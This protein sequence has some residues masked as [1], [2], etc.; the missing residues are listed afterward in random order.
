[1]TNAKNEA[2]AAQSGGR[3]QE[4]GVPYC[5]AIHATMSRSGTR[6]TGFDPKATR[7]TSNSSQQPPT[8][9]PSRFLGVRHAARPSRRVL[10]VGRSS[11]RAYRSFLP[12][13]SAS[14]PRR[15][16]KKGKDGRG[17]NGDGKHLCVQPS[18]GLLSFSSSLTIDIEL[19]LPIDIHL[20][21][22]AVII[23]A[24]L[25]SH[26]IRPIT[27]IP[28]PPLNLSGSLPPQS[29]VPDN[30][31]I[32]NFPFFF[33]GMQHISRAAH[34][35]NNHVHQVQISARQRGHDVEHHITRACLWYCQR[36]DAVADNRVLGIRATGDLHDV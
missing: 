21:L 22:F 2:A 13:S 35:D 16:M 4:V 28:L 30:L 15:L 14:G 20:L 29:I 8:G 25:C 34:D 31:N 3:H 23:P 36:V 6:G 9:W 32:N 1:M 27:P 33:A 24:S 10:R 7:S 18:D 17:M 26:L 5:D 11:P 19:Q 12:T